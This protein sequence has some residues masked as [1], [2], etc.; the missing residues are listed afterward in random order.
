V[1]GRT[2]Y[3]V[4][5]L[6]I[7]LTGRDPKDF[8]SALFSQ[9]RK[10]D[11]IFRTFSFKSLNTLKA[12]VFSENADLVQLLGENLS[13]LRILSLNFYDFVDLS[14]LS[15]LSNLLRIELKG[16]VRSEDLSVIGDCSKLKE[17]ILDW[18]VPLTDVE[19]P[20][21]VRCTELVLL[22]L[23]GPIGGPFFILFVDIF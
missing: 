3:C 13:S 14:P 15:T 4:H 7:I 18:G 2:R 16:K 1:N 11:Q 12:F 8:D 22:S 23:R 6:E 5:G 19:M 20:D 21:L 10:F 9:F 17:L